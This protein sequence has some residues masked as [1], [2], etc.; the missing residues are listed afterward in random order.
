M[1]SYI[2]I[3]LGADSIKLV[4]L[5]K[6]RKGLFLQKAGMTCLKEI[7]FY[8]DMSPEDLASEAIKWLL[9]HNEISSASAVVSLPSN[10]VYSKYITIPVVPDEKIKQIIQFEAMQQIPFPM[11]EICWDYT[12]LGKAPSGNELNVVIHVV[13]DAMIAS[14]TKTLAQAGIEIAIVDVMPMVLFNIMHL[15][16]NDH[17]AMLVDI[18]AKNTNIILLEQ[19]NCLTRSL[20]FGGDDFTEKIAK[21]L[22]I[23]FE[24]A[25]KFKREVG[26]QGEGDDAKI[27]EI[28]NESISNLIKEIQRT[29]GF[30]RSKTEELIIKKIL[31]T[32]GNVKIKGLLTL[33]MEH[34]RLD[35]EIFDPFK[36]IEISPAVGEDKLEFVKNYFSVAM[37]LARR[38]IDDCPSEINLIPKEILGAR[39]I[40][41]NKKF[42][43]MIAGVLVIFFALIGIHLNLSIDY[44]KKLLTK[45]VNAIGE[46][47]K[48][49]SDI[50]NYE[51]QIEP[52]SSKLVMLNS[53]FGQRTKILDLLLSVK[54]VS[55]NDFW[56]NNFRLNIA[57]E[58][59]DILK[60]YLT[61]EERKKYEYLEIEKGQR[62]E[63]PL[64]FNILILNGAATDSFAKIDKLR[65]SLDGQ[66]LFKKVNVFNA[67]EYSLDNRVYIKF[68]MVCEIK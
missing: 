18:G 21:Q 11:D 9:A 55:S 62:Q 58:D 19:G 33:F 27:S 23:P 38:Q 42:L 41:K 48:I 63:Y 64:G 68:D 16:G 36:G 6:T 4:Q 31:L 29:I 5:Q 56:F 8:E 14:F 39:Y 25:E 22:N 51:M 60:K 43:W 26:L 59:L 3:D 7:P 17:G 47:N 32:G 49:N 20:P 10:L 1:K 53:V 13:K 24:K 12:V 35:I 30:Y 37:G 34:L 67:E 15:T 61:K 65:I 28:L 45:A 46:L 66:N 54:N 57:Q 52:I 50:K 44:N 2:G 40:E